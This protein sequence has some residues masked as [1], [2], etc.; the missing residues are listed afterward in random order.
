[1]QARQPGARRHRRLPGAAVRVAPSG[2]ARRT[3][4][5]RAPG[6]TPPGARA[7]RAAAAASSPARGAQRVGVARDVQRAAAAQRDRLAAS[8]GREALA[9]PALEHEPERLLDASAPARAARPAAR[10]TSQCCA[11]A[12]RGRRGPAASAARNAA[13]RAGPARPAPAFSR[14]KPSSSAG[15][16]GSIERVGGAHGDV[17]AVE[18]APP[19][20]RPTCSRSS[21]AA[22]P[23]TPRRARRPRSC[24]ASASRVVSRHVRR[25]CSSGNPVPRSVA[26]DMAPTSSP[27]AINAGSVESEAHGGHRAC[28]ARLRNLRDAGARAGGRRHRRG[29]RAHGVAVQRG[30]DAGV[31]R[32]GRAHDRARAR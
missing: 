14:R 19:R 17:V 5:P 31:R 16:L 15:L 6:R 20:A 3:A 32:A 29:A 27:R 7:R 1:M 12:A 4:A 10:P 2:R 25:P 24:A 9:V 28:Q 11:N 18:H 8:A 30:R 13:A 21:A 22:P 26:R 23:S